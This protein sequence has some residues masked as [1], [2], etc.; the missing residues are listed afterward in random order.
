FV[1]DVIQLTDEQLAA[2]RKFLRDTT[3]PLKLLIAGRLIKI[4]GVDHVIEAIAK[5]REQNLPIKLDVMGEGEDL[6][7]FKQLV[8]DRRLVDVVR[9]TG[10][11][12][13]GKP[14]FDVWASAH[15]MA[16]TNLTAEI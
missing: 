5:L 16:V 13:Y 12:P 9:F 14:L 6:P 10:A 7:A 1:T 4:K 8:A 11:V 3:P 2:R 15:I